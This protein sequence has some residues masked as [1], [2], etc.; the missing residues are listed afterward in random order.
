M[1]D[2][3]EITKLIIS[4]FNKPIDKK[5]SEMN[6]ET[7]LKYIELYQKLILG[8]IDGITLKQKC[9]DNTL[10]NTSIS[11]PIDTNI[12]NINDIIFIEDLLF[13]Y[14]IIEYRKLEIRKQIVI[15]KYT[16]ELFYY[17]TICLLRLEDKQKNLPS[18]DNNEI[19][20]L[21]KNKINV[22]TILNNFIENNGKKF[23]LKK[24]YKYICLDRNFDIILKKINSKNKNN[25]LTK[26]IQKN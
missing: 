14:K 25:I 24:L 7:E 8:N 20:I 23:L 15:I 13:I 9:L 26:L 1:E 21:K 4:N 10:D 11:F 22:K 6:Y 19:N 17:L 2:I 18:I 12:T 5:E 16:L 3:S